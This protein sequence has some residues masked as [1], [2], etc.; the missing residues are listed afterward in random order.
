MGT[1]ERCEGKFP[2]GAGVYVMHLHDDY[3]FCGWACVLLFAISE[4]TDADRAKIADTWAA[5][6]VASRGHR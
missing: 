3:L 5:A 2:V 6:V 4:L 1:C